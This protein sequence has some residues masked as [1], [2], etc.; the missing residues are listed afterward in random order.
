LP[1]DI[2][3]A[4]SRGPRLLPEHDAP[5]PLL[6]VTVNEACRITGLGRTTL[7]E[8]VADGRLPLVKVGRRSV[9]PFEALRRLV[10]A[11]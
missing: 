10:G 5:A 2:H 11:P 9:I 3:N 1:R 6:A 7:Y 4:A 8:L